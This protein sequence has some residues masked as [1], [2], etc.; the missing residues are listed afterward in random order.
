MTLAQYLQDCTKAMGGESP[1]SIAYFCNAFSENDLY[2]CEDF[3]IDFENGTLTLD[4]GE[5]FSLNVV[6]TVND[7]GIFIFSH[8]D[9][10]IGIGPWF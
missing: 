4:E 7:D 10:Q 3:K 2:E 8:N 9:N 1:V 6:G 5:V